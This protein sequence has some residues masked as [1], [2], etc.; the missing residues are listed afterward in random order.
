[1][2]HIK[3][4]TGIILILTIS[5]LSLSCDVINLVRDNVDTTNRAYVR[6][7]EPSFIGN[8][9][10]IHTQNARYLDITLWD[11]QATF[12]RPTLRNEITGFTGDYHYPRFANW[13]SHSIRGRIN[14]VYL[15]NVSFDFMA[16][17]TGNNLHPVGGVGRLFN[18]DN[19]ER[20]NTRQTHF[21]SFTVDLRRSHIPLTYDFVHDIGVIISDGTTFTAR[22]TGANFVAVSEG[23]AMA[24][25]TNGINW[26]PI[27]VGTANW[28]AVT[29]GNGRYVAVGLN[30]AMAHS[31]NGITWT[32]MNVGA[33][34]WN[35]VTY[36]NGRYIAVGSNSTFDGVIAHSTNGINWTS[37]NIGNHWWGVTYGNGRYVAVGTYGT[38]AHSTNGV[39]WTQINAGL[40]HWLAV[41]AGSTGYVAV[42]ADGAM[43]H[44][45]N[46]INWIPMAVGNA[47]W[48]SVTFGNGRYVV[49]GFSGAMAHSTNGINWTQTNFGTNLSNWE[50]ITYGNGRFVA[51]GRGIA[52][53]TDGINWNQINL[54]M[55]RGVT[56]GN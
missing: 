33:T 36:G 49:G 26:N 35:A 51:V 24:H 12:N 20:L 47:L 14:Y 44:S 39:N 52:H 3:Y 22:P 1:M 45:F 19:S 9:H 43:A 8:F 15:G 5:T 54:G 31:T 2:R 4:I 7:W 28:N 17:G 56:S 16:Y 48:R 25:S 27:T 50:G 38:I 37:I 13:N 18:R 53:S 21:L 34:N 6:I 23:G 29:Y 42:S 40:T 10:H 30:G 46:G 11:F 32:Q 41:T 55:W